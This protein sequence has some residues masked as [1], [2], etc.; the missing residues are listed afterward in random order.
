MR[1]THEARSTAGQKP[2]SSSRA[3]R[4]ILLLGALTFLGACGTEELPQEEPTG[5]PGTWAEASEETSSTEQELTCGYQTV[6]SKTILN[7]AGQAMA[8]VEGQYDACTGRYRTTID[9]R[10]LCWTVGCWLKASVRTYGGLSGYTPLL[11]RAGS[12]CSSCHRRWGW[13][14]PAVPQCSQASSAGPLAGA[15]SGGMCGKADALNQ[16]GLLSATRQPWN[17]EAVRW[18]RRHNDLPRWKKRTSHG[19]SRQLPHCRPD[20]LYS[21][22]GAEERGHDE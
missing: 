5:A 10:N 22:R 21:V 17:K 8:R 2:P 4:G 7:A 13:G 9:R 14:L 18:A 15:T 19:A 6:C 20:G 1:H 16:R 11:P 12:G 3:A